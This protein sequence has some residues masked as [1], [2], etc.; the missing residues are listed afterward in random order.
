LN[1]REEEMAGKDLSL[2][3]MRQELP[4]D[5]PYWALSP[6]LRGV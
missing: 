3:I 1:Q 4:I 6:G 5:E 2:Q